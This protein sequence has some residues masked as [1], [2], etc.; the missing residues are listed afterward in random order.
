MEQMRLAQEEEARRKAAWDQYYAQQAAQQ[1]QARAMPPQPPARP[2]PGPGV[3]CRRERYIASLL[4]SSDQCLSSLYSIHFF[5]HF[6]LCSSLPLSVFVSIPSFVFFFSFRY[7]LSVSFL[8]SERRL[9]AFLFLIYF[10]F[11][12]SNGASRS[13]TPLIRTSFALTYDTSITKSL[14]VFLCCLLLLFCSQRATS[15]AIAT[16]S[17]SHSYSNG[18][19]PP[20]ASFVRS[21]ASSCRLEA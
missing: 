19:R 15:C 8:S 13:R 14:F 20:R 18:T 9:F 16:R 21:R 12:C 3:V 7:L 17:C 6:S 1:A 2:H 11:V 4:F 10:V 5:F